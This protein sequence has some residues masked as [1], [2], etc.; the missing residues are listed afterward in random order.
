[1]AVIGGPPLAHTN[2][3]FTALA[4]NALNALLGAVGRAG[5]NLLHARMLPQLSPEPRS[6]CGICVGE[7]AAARRSEP[8][9]CL[10]Q[11]LAGP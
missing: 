6:P 11:G 2:G 4:V 1:M 8:C 10:A 9:V 5:R 7:G 3:L